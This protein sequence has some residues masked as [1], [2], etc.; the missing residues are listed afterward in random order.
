M[1]PHFESFSKSSSNAST[2]KR[3]S[4]IYKELRCQLEVLLQDIRVDGFERSQS[5][6]DLL[7]LSLLVQDSPNKNAQTVVRD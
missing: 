7:F 3:L 5:E 1:K 6:G 2:W 4:H